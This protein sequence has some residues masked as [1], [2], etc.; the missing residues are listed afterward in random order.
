MQKRVLL[1]LLLVAILVVS[2][3]VL[4]ACSRN[5]EEPGEPPAQDEVSGTNNETAAVEETP[6]QVEPPPDDRLERHLRLP[7]ALPH[8]ITFN[9]HQVANE[10]EMNALLHANLFLRVVC[11]DAQWPIYVRQLASDYP[12]QMD[13][14]GL[15]WQIP[16]YSGFTFDDGTPINAHTFEFSQKMQIYP[17]LVNRNSNHNSLVGFPEFFM[18][19]IGWD[20]VTGFRVLNDY[21]IEIEFMPEFRP[22]FGMADVMASRGGMATAVVHPEVFEA[23]F[24]EDR[25]VNT[26]ATNPMDPTNFVASGIF[27]VSSYLTDQY[28]QF[29]KRNRG[30]R[31]ENYFTADRMSFIIVPNED[32]A[33]MMFENLELD[34]APANAARFNE[35]PDLFHYANGFVYGIFLNPFNPNNPILGD[36]NF[37]RALYWSL[38]RER[39]VGVSHPVSRPQAYLFPATTRMRLPYDRYSP[40][41]IMYR[42]SPQAQAI[43][44]NGHELTQFGFNPERALAYFDLAWEANGSVPVVIEVIYSD[45]GEAESM[46]AQAIQDAWQSLFGVDRLQITLRAVPWAVAL[47]NHLLRTA[48]YPTWDAY[49][50]VATRRIWQVL[51][52]EPWMNTNWVGPT[53]IFTWDGA[54]CILTEEAQAEFDRLFDQAFEA[55]FYDQALLNMTSA[56]VEELILN[57]HTFLPM[58]NH[59]DRLMIQ[60]WLT[61]IIPAGHYGFRAAPWQFI[62]D[63]ELHAQMRAE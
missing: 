19:E 10:F 12:Q 26:W 27:R 22:V 52:G 60:P 1:M 13:E 58:Y 47:E 62:W 45:A 5:G 54:Y 39:I 7:F 23:N 15:I 36:I 21:L 48:N 42:E 37:R 46:W 55:R 24:N 18:G 38:D 53:H 28:F 30:C 44:I 25:T 33:A 32:V 34:Q 35:M 29:E 11:P 20:E 63:D 3:A 17:G 56:W 43:T 51:D 6:T 61:T 4:V 50:I 41:R 16:I 8:T 40:S 57:D 9:Q 49:E 31:L 2:L 14:E 59:Q